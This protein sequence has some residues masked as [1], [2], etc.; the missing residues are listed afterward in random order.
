MYTY[1]WNDTAHEYGGTREELM[2]DLRASMHDWR[3]PDGPGVREGA[4]AFWDELG[5]ENRFQAGQLL[6]QLRHEDE[7]AITEV[8]D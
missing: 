3:Y 6:A 1:E 4:V 7:V 5:I 8:T 2:S